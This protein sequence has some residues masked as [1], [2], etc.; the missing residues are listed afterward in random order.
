MKAFVLLVLLLVIGIGV[1]VF[2]G[3]Y[4][5]SASNPDPALKRW[6]LST[7][8]DASIQRHAKAVVVPTLGAPDQLALGFRHYDEMCSVCHGSPGAELSP[9]ARGLNPR[10]PQF[11]KGTD[12]AP[13]ELFWV[14]KHGIQMTGMPA[15]GP[16]HTD[17]EIWAI[18]AFVPK[19]EKMT[20]AQYETMRREQPPLH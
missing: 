13:E 6:L 17:A 10:A 9:L 16:T 2:S 4:D 1:Y 3:A 19:L 12:L 5:V 15:W 7:V 8:S 18:V 14:T 11:S 20:R